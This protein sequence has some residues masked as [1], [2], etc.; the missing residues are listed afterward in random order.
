MG[1]STTLY[2]V[3]IPA[4][5]AA[6]GSVDAKLQHRLHAAIEETDPASDSQPQ[7]D[8]GSITPDS[9]INIDHDSVSFDGELTS[10][11]RLRTTLATKQIANLLVL[12]R[13][14][15]HV[16]WNVLEV[17]HECFPGSGIKTVLLDW[18]CDDP[19]VAKNIT[20]GPFLFRPMAE[21]DDDVSAKV[22]FGHVSHTAVADLLSG[23]LTTPSAE[24][25][26][27]LELF[28]HVLGNRLTDDDLLGDLEPLELRCP[29]EKERPPIPISVIGDF[30]I[31]SHL[32][33]SETASEVDRLAKTNLAYPADPD[34]EEAREALFDCLSS[35]ASQTLGVVSFYQ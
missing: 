5:I 10:A 17:I 3:D 27:A 11:E 14:P 33:S 30:P 15:N 31:I 26:Q 19:K 28:C 20:P 6:V 7:I 1:Y 32:D 4:L 25:A 13:V 9:T 12:Q 22:S 16:K 29:L 34:I 8:T 24:H 35:A 23:D 2:A 21:D 18:V